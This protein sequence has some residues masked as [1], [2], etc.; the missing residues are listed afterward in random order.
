MRR[1]RSWAMILALLAFAIAAVR[2][3]EGAGGGPAV[4]LSW[5][6]LSQMGGMGFFWAGVMLF[7]ASV[8]RRGG[9]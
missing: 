3:S 2:S 4:W 7:L 8:W 5:G 6:W 1:W 9:A